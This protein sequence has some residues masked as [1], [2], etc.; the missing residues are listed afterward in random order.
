M[1]TR[2]PLRK[3]GILTRRIGDE[4]MLYDSEKGD[5]HVINSTAEYVWRLCDGSH[6][7]SEIQRKM[8]EAFDVP[9][10][11]DIIKDID[12]IIAKFYDLGVLS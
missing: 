12:G 9:D 3:D 2:Q 11:V 6:S 1:D 7:I 5:I 8:Q 10:G 4:W